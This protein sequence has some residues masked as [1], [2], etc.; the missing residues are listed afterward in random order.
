MVKYPFIYHIVVSI[1][2]TSQYLIH[3]LYDKYALNVLAKLYSHKH[4]TLPALLCWMQQKVSRVHTNR[5]LQKHHLKGNKHLG[6]DGMN[7][8]ERKNK[9]LMD[10]HAHTLTDTHT[11]LRLCN[12]SRFTDIG[13]HIVIHNDTQICPA[14]AHLCMSYVHVHRYRLHKST[15]AR[16]CG[17]RY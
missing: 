3:R 6:R 5:N 4:S 13:T 9:G 15:R 8:G 12:I 2:P 14:Y 7:E 17:R 1:L 11:P 10:A 16:T